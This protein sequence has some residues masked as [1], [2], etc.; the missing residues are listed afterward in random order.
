MQTLHPYL[1]SL[2]PQRG[3][4]VDINKLQ[5][6][7]ARLR[8][9]HIDHFA[10]QEVPDIQPTNQN[11]ETEDEPAVADLGLYHDDVRRTLTD[12]QIAMFRH[13]EIQRLLAERRRKKETEDDKKQQTKQ[14]RAKNE[15]KRSNLENSDLSR[16]D[17]DEIVHGRPEIKE[18]S[19]D[20][21]AAGESSADIKPARQF[22]W[23]ILPS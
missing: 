21:D 9:F 8:S 14:V 23:P 11:D 6:E 4:T 17:N 3:Y 16:F 7:V 10:G 22:Q 13:S 19:Y 12:E 20:D 15:T 18:L 2:H 1:R 5:V